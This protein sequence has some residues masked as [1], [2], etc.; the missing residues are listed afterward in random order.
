[1]TVDT[2]AN[3]TVVLCKIKGMLLNCGALCD[4]VIFVH[5][6]KLRNT[7]EFSKVEGPAALLKVTRL[8]VC[9]SQFLVCANGTKSWKASHLFR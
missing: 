4:L 7:H 6:K 9:F 8:H 1:M 2:I 3:S 5:F